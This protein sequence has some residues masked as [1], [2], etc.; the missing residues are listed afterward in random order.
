MKMGMYTWKLTFWLVV[1]PKSYNPLD[2]IQKWPVAIYK[3][4]TW[5]PYRIVLETTKTPA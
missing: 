4:V 2:M 1:E 3:D 5:L